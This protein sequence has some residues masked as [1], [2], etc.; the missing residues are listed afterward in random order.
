VL[1]KSDVAAEVHRGEATSIRSYRIGLLRNIRL[2]THNVFMRRGVIQVGSEEE[3][4]GIDGI[5]SSKISQVLT[6]AWT[7]TVTA[8]ETVVCPTSGPR[9]KGVLL[10]VED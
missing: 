10:D 8:Q 2:R 7:S 5:E 4:G 9:L 3:I 1:F 6:E